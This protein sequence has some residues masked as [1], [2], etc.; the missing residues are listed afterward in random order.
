MFFMWSNRAKLLE[1]TYMDAARFEKGTLHGREDATLRGI[2]TQL[3]KQET[4]AL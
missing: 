4:V 2:T 1:K 3:L